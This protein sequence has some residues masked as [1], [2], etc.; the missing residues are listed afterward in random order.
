MMQQRRL[1]L[2]VRVPRGIDVTG[3]RSWT[4]DATWRGEEVRIADGR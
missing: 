3:G 2:S 1:R 4:V